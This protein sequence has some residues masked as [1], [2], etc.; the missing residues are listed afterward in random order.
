[1]APKSREPAPGQHDVRGA[2]VAPTDQVGSLL[3]QDAEVRPVQRAVR[4]VVGHHE[5]IAEG[6]HRV[7]GPAVGRQEFT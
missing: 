4:H 5:V 2:V 7:G 3:P 6:Q 1:M